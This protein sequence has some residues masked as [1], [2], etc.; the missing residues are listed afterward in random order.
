VNKPYL[1]E[2]LGNE[3]G[4]RHQPVCGRS[5]ARPPFQPAHTLARAQLVETERVE[6]QTRSIRRGSKTTIFDSVLYI[7]IICKI[8]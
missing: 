8:S 5:R 3:P 4:P 6:Q 1:D 2:K 7:Y